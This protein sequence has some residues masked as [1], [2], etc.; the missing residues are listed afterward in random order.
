[1]LLE[2]LAR[3]ERF[4]EIVAVDD[5]EPKAAGRHGVAVW[6]AVLVERDLHAS[7]AGNALDLLDQTGGG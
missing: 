7:H 5:G 1:M 6:R 4:A 3:A 2:P